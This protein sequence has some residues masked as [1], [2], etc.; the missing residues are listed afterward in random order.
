MLL[1]VATVE[2]LE[3]VL[4][5]RF[6]GTFPGLRQSSQLQRGTC[7]CA[8]SSSPTRAATAGHQP[9]GQVIGKCGQ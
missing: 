3:L 4:R 5:A 6:H 9:G 1:T 8:R 7:T 2:K